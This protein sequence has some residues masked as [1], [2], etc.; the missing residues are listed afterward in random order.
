MSL[1]KKSVFGMKFCMEV[2]IIHLNWH[3]NV[4]TINNLCIF[5]KLRFLAFLNFSPVIK[6]ND[7]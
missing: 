3:H 6:Y 7:L 2:T 4:I 1:T 5:N